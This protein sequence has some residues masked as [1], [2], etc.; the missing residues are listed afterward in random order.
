MRNC[1]EIVK[2]RCHPERSEGS[3]ALFQVIL[4]FA[5]DSSP[6]N[7]RAQND[8]LLSNP[9]GLHAGVLKF[10]FKHGTII[11]VTQ[12]MKPSEGY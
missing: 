6:A 5:R 2:K 11:I 8:N 3:L 12:K 7:W 9:E 1:S 4:T 10:S